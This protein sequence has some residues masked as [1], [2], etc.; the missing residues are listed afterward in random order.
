MKKY[1]RAEYLNNGYVEIFDNY[2]LTYNSFK[3]YVNS[4]HDGQILIEKRKS[5]SGRL[6]KSKI[7]ST[8]IENDTDTS[9]YY[10][11]ITGEEYIKIGTSDGQYGFE[12]ILLNKGGNLEL[13]INK[14]YSEYELSPNRIAEILKEL[15]P[16]EIEAYSFAIDNLK[17]AAHVSVNIIN[18]ELRRSE[19]YIEAFKRNRKK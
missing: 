12:E 3:I 7:I 19:D 13:R 2:N 4:I 1:Y 5:F 11:I 18:E 17:K 9:K 10:D 14:L 8:I 6:V 16:V 15:T